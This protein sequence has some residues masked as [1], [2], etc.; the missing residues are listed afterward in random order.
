MKKITDSLYEISLGSVNAFLIE[1]DGLTLVDPGLPG[2]ADKLL[3]AIRQG[4][5]KPEDIRQIILTHWHPD[6]AGNAAELQQ[7]LKARVVAHTAEAS[8]LGQGGGP[9][10][11]YLTPGLV[12]WLVFNVFIKNLNPNIV[13]VQVDEQVADNEVLPVAGGL[14]V[15]HTPG[16]SAGHIALL[17]ERE[18]VLIA[19]DACANVMG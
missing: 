11:R 9:R 15:V 13:P 17:L 6:H 5:K 10:P 3:A 2:T 8:I 12:N 19:G 14:R 16:H 7:C 1:D 4:G 18:G